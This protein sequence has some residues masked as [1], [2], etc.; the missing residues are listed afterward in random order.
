MIWFIATTVVALV[1][2]LVIYLREN[3]RV[4]PAF[5]FPLIT[6]TVVGAIVAVLVNVA[7]TSIDAPYKVK[8]TEQLV[9]MNDG[10]LSS[11]Q[12]FLIAGT[13]NTVNVYNFY[14]KGAN[15][16]IQRHQ[17]YASTGTIYEE[18]GVAPSVSYWYADNNKW[19][20]LFTDQPSLET[21]TV[22]AGSIKNNVTLDNKN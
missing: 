20:Q 22:P 21:F 13:Y 12:F 10:D 2:S 17:T 16:G 14:S 9:A 7:L 5:W 6:L 18:D 1:W 19:W 15:G 3:E 8:Y 11:G 4:A